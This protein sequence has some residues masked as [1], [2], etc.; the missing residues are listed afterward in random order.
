MLDMCNF[1]FAVLYTVEFQ[2]RGLPHAHILVWFSEDPKVT[3][4]AIDSFISAEIPDPIVD[5]LGYSLV[6]EFMM[7]GPCGEMNDKCVC[8]K[9]GV[10]SKYFPKDFQTETTIDATGFTLY[11]R[12]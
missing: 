5:L 8:M 4:E 10:C 3:T 6:S 2:K 9:K 1:L 11:R 12:S 7:H